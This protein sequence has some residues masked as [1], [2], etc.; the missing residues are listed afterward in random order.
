[1]NKETELKVLLLQAAK[2]IKALVGAP[3]PRIWRRYPNL[4]RQA[5]EFL[6]VIEELA[7]QEE[8]D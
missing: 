5:V 2:L 1:M 4:H 6:A 3:P 7:C 8:Q